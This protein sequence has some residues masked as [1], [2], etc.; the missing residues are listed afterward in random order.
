MVA[1]SECKEG[2]SR[3]RRAAEHYAEQ[4]DYEPE[5]EA[6]DEVGEAQAEDPRRFPPRKRPPVTDKLDE[7]RYHESEHLECGRDENKERSVALRLRHQPEGEPVHQAK[8]VKNQVNVKGSKSTVP[9]ETQKS[10]LRSIDK[11]DGGG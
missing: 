1:P 5:T 6:R 4:E 10:D 11:K 8:G 7:A 2:Y 3:D 9:A